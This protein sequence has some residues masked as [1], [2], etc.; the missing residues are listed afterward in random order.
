M[1]LRPWMRHDKDEI[2]IHGAPA[3]HRDVTGPKVLVPRR[4]V[5]SSPAWRGQGPDVPNPCHADTCQAIAGA[6]CISISMMTFFET[7]TPPVS[8][9]TFQLKPQSSRLIVV[10]AE[11][12]AF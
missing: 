9:G 1:K 3:H 12:A 8:R 11:K 6:A 10:V 5:G 2:E 7:R 4:R